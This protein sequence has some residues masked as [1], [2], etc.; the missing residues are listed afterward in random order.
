MLVSLCRKVV[1][2]G[3]KTALLTPHIACHQAYNDPTHDLC[4]VVGARD[5]RLRVISMGHNEKLEG[6]ACGLVKLK[7][8]YLERIVYPTLRDSTGF[9]T[10]RS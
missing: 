8:T 3:D 10:S 4:C 6:R 2:D 1:K 5:L 7:C 9:C